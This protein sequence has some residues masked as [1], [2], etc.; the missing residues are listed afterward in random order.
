MGGVP[1]E[2]GEFLDQGAENRVKVSR[3]KF[4]GAGAGGDNGLAGTV[5]F[6]D[7]GK[8]IETGSARLK[9]GHGHLHGPSYAC[10]FVGCVE[11]SLF[12]CYT[13]TKPHLFLRYSDDCIG[14]ASCSHEELVQFINFTNTFPPNLKF[15]WTISDTFLSFLDLSV[16]ISDDRLQ[17]DIYFKPMDSHS[18]LDY[19]FSHPPSCKNAI[20]YSQ[21][22][23]LCC[24]CSQDGAFHTRTFQ[25]SSYFRDCNFPLCGDRSFHSA[26]VC[27][28]LPTNLTTP[29]TFPYN[30]RKCCTCPYISPI[31]SVQDTKQ[32]FH[33]RQRFTCTSV[34]L[35]YCICFS[36][37]GFLY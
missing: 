5:V 9:G 20:S 19:T 15:T 7:F 8:E 29:S 4:S 6:A 18:Y 23:H 10:L 22:L 35:I 27:S 21:F 12:C 36:G 31:P 16:S 1:D 3:D 17:T 13:G 30:H 33:M 28:T 26:L 32:T 25:M 34:N 37:F 24:I 11:Q 14:I 2:G